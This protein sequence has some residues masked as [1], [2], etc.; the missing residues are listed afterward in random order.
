MLACLRFLEWSA[1][2]FCSGPQVS[3][4]VDSSRKVDVPK[5]ASRVE[6]CW[7]GAVPGTAQG[8]H[9]V[10]SPSASAVKHRDTQT[11]R[12]DQTPQPQPRKPT[13]RVCHLPGELRDGQ[14]VVWLT[15][16][17]LEG[18]C[19]TPPLPGVPEALLAPRSSLGASLFGRQDPPAQQF[20]TPND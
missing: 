4:P 15:G 2:R 1:Q 18:H 7:E 11:V 6:S 10:T 5:A 16:A 12:T 14:G 13:V 8:N 9:W 3:R 17:R 19:R 20:P